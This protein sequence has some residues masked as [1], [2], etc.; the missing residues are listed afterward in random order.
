LSAGLEQVQKVLATWRKELPSGHGLGVAAGFWS[1]AV[2]AGG[3]VRLR[4]GPKG[5]R[6]EQAERDIGSGSVIRGLV[7]V[8]ERA[9]GLPAEAISVVTL[10]TG[11]APFDSGVFGSRTVAALGQ[12]IERA[13][14]HL[15]AAL[16]SRV[17]GRGKL[18]LE[19]DG[20]EVQVRSGSTRTPLS[21]L[22]TPSERRSGGVVAEGRFYGPSGKIDERRVL[23]GSFY[24][25][26]DYCA[27]VHL[28][29][30]AVD[31]ETGSVSVV[32]YLAVQ[33]VGVVLDPV[34]VRGQVEGAVAM[35][36]G[37][38]LTEESLWDGTGRLLNPGLLDYR[39]PTLGEIPSI[40]VV[41]LEGFSG[42]GPFGAKGVG[43]PPI[44]PVI[45]AVANAVFDA[46][47][48][49]VFE[50]PLSAERVARALRLL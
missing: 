37:E 39:V 21:K 30:V 34:M 31:R 28:A 27:T 43:E 17:R 44:I 41:T 38:A 40:E 36:L 15:H 7:A 50:S 20:G 8:T 33:D 18:V 24:P 4:L 26:S 1:T 2:G 16:R 29:E 14:H 5:L 35:G 47:G 12:A 6:V 23:D 25:Y 46:T 10:D 22:L 45:A 11:T 48:A 49:R 9:V 13:A 19:I 3:E 42:A 32:R